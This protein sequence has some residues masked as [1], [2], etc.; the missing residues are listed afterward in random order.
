MNAGTDNRRGSGAKTASAQ[1]ADPAGMVTA[2]VDVAVATVWT[3]STSPRA[4]IDAPAVAN[5]V[6]MRNS[7]SHSLR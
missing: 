3:S 1:T 7:S 6:T 2:Y 5:P 4:K